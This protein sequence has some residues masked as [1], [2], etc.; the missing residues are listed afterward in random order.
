[1]NKSRMPK[2][3]DAIV[4][5]YDMFLEIAHNFIECQLNLIEELK[6]EAKGI[7]RVPTYVNYYTTEPNGV[8]L[9]DYEKSK[10]EHEKKMRVYLRKT[11]RYLALK[12]LKNK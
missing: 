3:I 8:V 12:G 7:F 11:K 10:K 9:F 1:M 6:E 4:I 2:D 5:E